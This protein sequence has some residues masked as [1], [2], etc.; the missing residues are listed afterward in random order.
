MF[1]S[2]TIYLTIISIV[3][4][5]VLI[6]AAVRTSNKLLA[7]AYVMIATGAIGNVIDRFTQTPYGG[8]GHVTDFIR[9]YSWPT[10]ILPIRL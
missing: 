6:I 1:Q 7:L 2:S 8:H 10:L 3:V 9:I 5:V 4:I